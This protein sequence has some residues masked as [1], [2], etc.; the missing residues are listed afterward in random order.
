MPVIHLPDRGVVKV[1]GEDARSF[2]NGLV[3]CDMDKVSPANAGFGALLSPQG[4][5]M[6][7]FII[8]EAEPQDGGGFFLDTLRVLAPDLMQRL[9]MYKL[10]AR[11]I[12]EDLSDILG[13][14]VAYGGAAFN[15]DDYLAYAD[16]RLPQL[17]HR[18]IGERHGLEKVGGKTLDYHAH[19]LSL[20]VP[21]GGK[22]FAF[23]D[24][25]P[26]EVLMDQINGVDFRKGCYVGQEVVSRMEHRGTARTRIVPVEYEGGF[27][28]IEGIDVISAGKIIGK[29]GSQYNGKGLALLRL[30]RLADALAAGQQV[31]AGGIPLKAV[32]PAFAKFDVPGA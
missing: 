17:G 26:H 8:A 5:V 9:N 12:V 15:A 14:A 28:A 25:F 31:A 10:R 30:D 4:K 20:S 2:L 27:A 1:V 6:F 16:P 7:D 3:T 21:E 24:V 18:L 29:T 22:D 32:K 11:V 13:V 23:N 19:R